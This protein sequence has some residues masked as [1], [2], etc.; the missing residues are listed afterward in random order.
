MKFLMYS[1]FGEGSHILM[2]IRNEGNDCRLY[3]KDKNYKNVFDGMLEKL[4]NED[5]I[6]RYVDEGTVIIFDTSG[7][8]KVAD[9]LRKRGHRVVGGSDFCDRLEKDR[10]FGF[11]V[12]Q[13]S[14]ISIP[15]YKEF[16]GGEYENAKKYIM[17]GDKNLV[18]KPNGA[19]IK[20]TYVAN[21]QIE[22]IKYLEFI[23]ER[24]SKEVES[25]I[26]QEFIEGIAISSEFFCN[27]NGFVR[28][29]NHTI[30]EKKFMNE[31][32][33]PSSG[34]SGNITWPCE[35]TE[36]MKLGVL[37]LEDICK[38]EEL[39]G[40]MDLN[41]IANENGVYG[42]EFTPRTGYDATPTLLTLIEDVGKFYS[43]LCFRGNGSNSNKYIDIDE[44]FAGSV[45]I[46]IPPYPIET[47]LTAKLEE[48]SPNMGSPIMNW[49]HYDENI[50]FYEVMRNG[51]NGDL[52]HSSGSGI[53]CLG[54]GTGDEPDDSMD[55]AYEI[56][57]NIVIPD[58]QYRTDLKETL[59]EMVSEAEKYARF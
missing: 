36:I 32:L 44:Q 40:Q 56:A 57:E 53:I 19:Q 39:I 37:K 29:G 20:L 25:F 54:I 46:T 47:K 13:S 4:D 18:F 28:P 52:V 14:G 7:N 41:C 50:Y 22:L 49:E 8:G 48:L 11:D 1:S 38:R 21:E 27:G 5:D 55:L 33:G 6:G 17:S 35:D 9:D 31:G 24:Y 16:G 42:L 2:R 23:E 26:I 15:R 12:M 10:K 59:A 45:R 51:K 34:C 58:K 43:D 30:E 3:I